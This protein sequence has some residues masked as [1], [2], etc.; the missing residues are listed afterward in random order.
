ME[1]IYSFE[2]LEV[3]KDAKDLAKDIYRITEK[4]PDFEKF[5][6]ANQLRRAVISVSSNIAEGS[7]RLSDK[8]KGHFYMIA[9]SSLMELYNQLIIASELELIIL[10]D[11]LKRKIKKISNYLNKLHKSTMTK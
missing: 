8:S 10:S 2:K 11:D 6:I 9:Y 5:G 7:S 1:H 4:F 3:W